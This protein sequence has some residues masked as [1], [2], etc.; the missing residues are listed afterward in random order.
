[1]TGPASNQRVLICAGIAHAKSGDRKRLQRPRHAAVDYL[2]SPKRYKRPAGERGDAFFSRGGK[3][4]NAGLQVAAAG[5]PG[6]RACAR[7]LQKN[8]GAAQRRALHMLGAR[9]NSKV[10]RIAPRL[11]E[12]HH[13]GL[14][15]ISLRFALAFPPPLQPS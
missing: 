4:A 2:P 13:I 11:C 1:M 14:I 10:R 3:S 7:I 15:V 5:G 9:L 8:L 6:R 12:L